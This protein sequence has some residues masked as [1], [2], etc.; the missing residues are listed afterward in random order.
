MYK[1][2]FIQKCL[3]G[4]ALYSD[5]DDYVQEWHENETGID[6][7]EFLGMTENEYYSWVENADVLKWIIYS[8]KNNKAFENVCSEDIVD[9]AARGTDTAELESI[10]AWLKKTGRI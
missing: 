10:I 8:H 4:E 9:I 1:D 5:I 3:R 2:S 7:H 6:M